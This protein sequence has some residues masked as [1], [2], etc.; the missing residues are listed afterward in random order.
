VWVGR[1]AGGGISATYVESSDLRKGT[2]E[3]RRGGGREK[4]RVVWVSCT[5]G[6]EIHTLK[7]RRERRREGDVPFDPLQVDLSL[8]PSPFSLH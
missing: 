5:G 7:E 2:R 6:G 1:T 8:H 4:G 3:G